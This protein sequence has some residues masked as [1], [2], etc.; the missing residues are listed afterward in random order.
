LHLLPWILA[1]KGGGAFRPGRFIRFSRP[2]DRGPS[3]NNLFVSLANY[4]GVNVTSF[5]NRDV[6]TGP[7]SELA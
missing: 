3:H 7:L 5:G 6:C 4:M 1:G 2:N